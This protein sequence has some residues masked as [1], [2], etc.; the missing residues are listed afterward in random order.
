MYDTRCKL[1]RMIPVILAMILL[2][3]ATQNSFANS[4]DYDGTWSSTLSCGPL[5]RPGPNPGGFS[6]PLSF[7]IDKGVGRFEETRGKNIIK[8]EMQINTKKASA[9]G[10]GSGGN[11]GFQFRLSGKITTDSTIILKGAIYADGNVHRDCTLTGLLGVPSSASIAGKAKSAA[12]QANVAA[13]IVQMPKPAPITQATKPAVSMPINITERP[14]ALS[15]EDLKSVQT[16]LQAAGYYSGV[17]DGIAGSRTEAAIAAWQSAQKMNPTGFTTES[18]FATLKKQAEVISSQSAKI[19]INRKPENSA[20]QRKIENPSASSL[21]LVNSQSTL[22]DKF[23]N[24]LGS[25]TAE[26]IF[27]G[28][29]GDILLFTNEQPQ[30]PHFFRRV[31]GEGAFRNN[32]MNIC[33]VGSVRSLDGVFARYATRALSKLSMNISPQ[34]SSPW[35]T[36]CGAINANAKDDVIAVLRSDLIKSSPLQEQIFGA[37]AEKKLR[38]FNQIDRSPFD[39]LIARREANGL[40]LAAQ[41]KAGTLNGLGLLAT[42]TANMTV[43]ATSGGDAEFV[44][45]VVQDINA[46]ILA[47]KEPGPNPK[48]IFADI[49]DVFIRTKRDECGFVYGDGST[50][51]LMADAFQRD[52]FSVYLVQDVISKDKA[53]ALLAQVKT[54]RAAATSRLSN[55][56]AE[57]ARRAEEERRIKLEQQAA[58]LQA[59]AQRR[60]A[61]EQ[62]ERL[63][64]VRRANDEA[65]RREELER[66]R[67][68]VSSRG[69]AIQDTLDMRIRKHIAS[70]VKEV[71]DT[72]QRAKLGQVLTVAEQ[73][74]LDARN[75]ADRLVKDFPIWSQKVS[76][77]AKEEWDFGD[78]KASL[79]D[80][81]QAK[82]RGRTIEAISVR[83]ETPMSNAV[84]GERTNDC[85][86]FTWINDEEFKFWRQNLSSDCAAYEADFKKWANVNQFISQWK[87]P[88]N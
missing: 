71:A 88:A 66:I 37:L 68:V 62:Q 18:Q 32:K 73:R 43:C 9:V 52:G 36:A 58:E 19:E 13:P 28:N 63:E 72:K 10:Y 86:I 79:E 84:I 60:I 75:E 44:K 24:Q 2:S 59:Q 83:V 33:S 46:S 81:G 20:I 56:Q 41:L 15:F 49:D 8:W 29:A 11:R 70:L 3:F 27:V 6:R 47:G 26:K 67:R 7:S 25:Q 82:W 48:L 35:T 16:A 78:I 53:D 34:S 61:L 57:Q 39:L 17:V 12:A 76:Q 21:G 77:R 64:E 4:T 69:R 5:L 1:L 51:K 38:L 40:A 54:E 74:A 50:L 55:D 80:Y 45:K 23:S 31:T 85:T 87:L 22:Q 65:A 42:Q 14:R 30:A